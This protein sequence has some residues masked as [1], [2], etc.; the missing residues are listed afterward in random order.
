MRILCTDLLVDLTQDK[1]PRFSPSSV[2]SG[3]DRSRVVPKVKSEWMWP[4]N[5][6][7]LKV[8]LISAMWVPKKYRL[9]LCSHW[10]HPWYQFA[11]W[12]ASVRTLDSFDGFAD[13][14][15]L[16]WYLSTT[17]DCWCS[18]QHSIVIIHFIPIVDWNHNDVHGRWRIFDRTNRLSNWLINTTR[19]S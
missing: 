11:R 1:A 18:L 5:R 4:T 6:Q 17:I 13:D 9:L 8:L 7:S 3:T 2:D 16:R 10:P 12:C 15:P 14:D 19:W